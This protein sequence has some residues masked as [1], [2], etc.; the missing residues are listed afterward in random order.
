MA[1][2]IGDVNYLFVHDQACGTDVLDLARNG[3]RLR[4]SA[5]AVACYA[6]R[7]NEGLTIPEI[8]ISKRG[9]ADANGILQH[10]CKHRLKIARGACDDLEHVGRGSLLLQRFGQVIVRWRSSLSSRAFSMAMTAWAAKFWTNSIC[11]SVN[12]RTS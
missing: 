8:N 10:G 5:K 4:L 9:I 12:G 2:S 3:E 6:Q 1:A 11:L 7:L